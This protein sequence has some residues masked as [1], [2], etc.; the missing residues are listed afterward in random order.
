M[1]TLSAAFFAAVRTS[2]FSDKLNQGQVDGMQA[3]ASAFE[4]DGDGNPRHLAYILATDKWET[5]HTMQPIREFGR[6][7][8]KKYG[9]KDATGQV[10]YGRGLIQLTWDYNYRKADDELGLGGALVRNY[11]LALEMDIAARILV[12][13]MLE[14]W[15]TTRKLS[16]FT[17]Y[18]DM[19]RVVNGLDRA[20]DIALM[21]SKFEAAL[22][23]VETQ[24]PSEASEQ[25]ASPSSPATTNWLAVVVQ[26]LLTLLRSFRK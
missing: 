26:F 20:D 15:F 4:R 22:S 5:A 13:G 24:E 11:D 3:V 19:R 6:G 8:G 9:K 16:D 2:L 21:A 14:G 18:R 17:S 12:R 25:P 23:L 10:P 7:K 1:P